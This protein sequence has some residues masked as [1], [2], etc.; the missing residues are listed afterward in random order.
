M[1]SS[2]KLSDL[3][4][5]P[6]KNQSVREDVAVHFILWSDKTYWMSEIFGGNFKKSVMRCYNKTFIDLATQICRY[7]VTKVISKK[8]SEFGPCMCDKANKE[9]HFLTWE[10]F[11]IAPELFKCNIAS[12]N[13]MNTL[14]CFVY[15]F[16]F[17]FYS[18]SLFSFLS[19]FFVWKVSQLTTF[20][21]YPW[22]RIY[23]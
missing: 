16:C 18:I 5:F 17:D 9:S 4:D 1:Q 14:N 3:S 6:I 8:A 13:G 21:L 22:R 19:F 2:W 23:F 12:W 7:W 15:N 20:Q 10:S 11:G